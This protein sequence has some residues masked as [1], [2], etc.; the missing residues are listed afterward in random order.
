MVNYS[1]QLS[2]H[3]IFI[4]SSLYYSSVLTMAQCCL[5]TTDF[6]S[7]TCYRF[8]L[9]V[10]P[11]VKPS[12][13]C[14]NSNKSNTQDDRITLE[15]TFILSRISLTVAFTISDNTILILN[16]ITNTI[17]FN[18]RDNERNHRFHPRLLTFIRANRYPLWS[19]VGV[20][21]SIDH[22]AR[23][24]WLPSLEQKYG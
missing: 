23:A 15:Q 19:T 10:K 6:Q 24:L 18:V 5:R 22:N 17:R 20:K 1:T 14:N 7:D 2:V 13:D 12:P 16:T 21:F 8:A 3:R 11:Q 4:V 9:S